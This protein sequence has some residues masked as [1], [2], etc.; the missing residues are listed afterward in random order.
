MLPGFSAEA[1]LAQA[2][3]RFR[4][5]RP[6]R[7]ADAGIHPAQRNVALGGRVTTEGGA[8]LAGGTVCTCPCCQMH[9]GHLVCC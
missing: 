8:D 9:H 1:G 7:H 5:R 6:V 3:E 4:S 2:R